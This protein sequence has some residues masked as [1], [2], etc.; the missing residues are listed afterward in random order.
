VYVA[1]TG[2][3]LQRNPDTVRAP[4]VSFVCRERDAAP[5]SRRGFVPGAP[6]LAI[7]IR[8]PDNTLAELATKAAEYL[9]A[10]ARL[11]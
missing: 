10:G 11:V 5:R 6:D 7:E 8:S 1:E 3:T 4:D 2:F 9:E